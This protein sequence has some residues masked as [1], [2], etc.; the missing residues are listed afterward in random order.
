M[1]IIFLRTLI[2]TCAHMVTI[3]SGF[4]E[5]E[6]SLSR[7]EPFVTCWA[8]WI[9]LPLSISWLVVTLSSYTHLVFRLASS[10][11]WYFS[12]KT[13]PTFIAFLMIFIL[14]ATVEFGFRAWLLLCKESQSSHCAMCIFYSV[15]LHKVLR[16]LERTT[17]LLHSDRWR[18][19]L[20]IARSF[21]MYYYRD[22]AL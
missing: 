21:A 10:F 19:P 13:S 1:E 3:H 5:T 16:T 8:S 18:R 4:M 2:C 12:T 6:G 20:R 11:P 17:Y 7:E 14:I 22:S 9:H 15:F